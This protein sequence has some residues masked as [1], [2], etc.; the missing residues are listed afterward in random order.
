MAKGSSGSTSRSVVAEIINARE[1]IKNSLTTVDS[2]VSV[3]SGSSAPSAEM[4]SRLHQ[5]DKRRKKKMMMMMLISLGMM[6][7]KT[8]MPKE[9]SRNELQHTLLENQRNLS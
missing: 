5:L 1:Q 8:R 7:K 3:T 6:M 4:T 2:V 9:S